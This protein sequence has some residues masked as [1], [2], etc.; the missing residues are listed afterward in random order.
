MP[1]ETADTITG[2]A[3]EILEAPNY[4]VLS[5]ARANG[6]VQ[7]NIVWADIDG[8]NIL[9]N[10]AIGRHWPANLQKVKHATVLAM[11][12]NNPFEWVAVE[13]E[14]IS[15][16]TDGANEE[17]DRLAK[18][19]LGVDTYPNHRADEQRISFRLR[20][21]RVKYVKQG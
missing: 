21:E 13:G 19:Y 16:T 20:P 10:S 12:D 1:I 5:I 8:E 17:I 18:K 9:L 3:R 4:V 14:L 6:T 2:R 15:A 11:A 7:S